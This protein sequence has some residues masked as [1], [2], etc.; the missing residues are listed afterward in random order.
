MGKCRVDRSENETIVETPNFVFAESLVKQSEK[1]DALSLKN[2]SA[3][4]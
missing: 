3:S 2:R 4:I 1:T